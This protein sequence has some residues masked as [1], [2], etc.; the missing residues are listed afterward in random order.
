MAE[1]GRVDILVNNSATNIGQGPALKV[2]DGM[3][4]KMVEVNVKSALRLVR[5]FR[6]FKL[7]RYS[8]AVDAFIT[9]LKDRREKLVIAV[10]TNLL[11]LIVASSAMYVVEHRAQPE[12]FPSIPETM[13]WGVITLTTV[14]YG[15]VVP[16]TMLGQAVGAIVAILG[17]GMFALPAALI[18][19]GFAEAT[20]VE[21]CQA[22]RRDVEAYVGD[23]EETR[24][25]RI[26]V[27]PVRLQ[28]Q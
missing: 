22:Q 25:V 23:L 11:L 18:A 10:T 15:D 24:V 28:P 27:L 17:I 19:T 20:G 1:F 12:V 9:V 6:L 13:W 7:A 21:P 5:L 4:D 8:D 3:L 26:S 2:D 14:G 16:A